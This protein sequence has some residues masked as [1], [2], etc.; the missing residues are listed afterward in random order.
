MDSNQLT[1]I[2]QMIPETNGLFKGCFYN[3]NI[4]FQLMHEKECFFI[5]NTIVDVRKMGHWI[6]FYIRNHHLYFFD[7]FAFSPNDYEWDIADFFNT[8]PT[9]KTI[10]FSNQIQNE[11][12]YVCGV[13][14]IFFG[15]FMSK[16]YSINRIKSIFTR[17]TRRN[18]SYVVSFLHSLVGITLTCEQKYCHAYMYSG[19]CRK[20][21]DC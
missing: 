16:K 7:S 12:S 1:Q 5:V 15:Y 4:P 20:Y 6:L 17:N 14:T 11:L 19:K 18:D 9:N 13:Y 2:L 21:C 10:V 3:R 8:Y